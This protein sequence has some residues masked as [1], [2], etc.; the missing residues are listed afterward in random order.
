MVGAY[1]IS[2]NNYSMIFLHNIFTLLK[3]YGI[4][5]KSYVVSDGGIIKSFIRS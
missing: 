2:S 5:C 1:Y 3:K 4:I